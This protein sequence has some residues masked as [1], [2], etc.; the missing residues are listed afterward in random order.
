MTDDE[1][2]A[3]LVRH[4]SDLGDQEVVHKIYR[5][6][7]A[8]E[9]PQSGE[10]IVGVANL[11][12]M[13]TAYPARV[14][15]TLRRIRGGGEFWVAEHVLTSDEGR[16]THAVNILEL[17]GGKVAHETIYFGEPWEPPAWRSQW[18]EVEPAAAP[19]P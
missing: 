5:D 18:G 7:V 9:F 10:R 6:V 17:H 11:R 13:H 3:A 12:A 16:P 14:A 1:I 4:W 15:T 19:T 2:R 8:V